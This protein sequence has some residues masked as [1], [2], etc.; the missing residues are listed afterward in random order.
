MHRHW[1]KRREKEWGT[2]GEWLK[3]SYLFHIHNSM[4]MTIRMID[5]TVCN[6]QSLYMRARWISQIYSWG[7]QIWDLG[8][9]YTFDIENTCEIFS[10][11]SREQRTVREVTNVLSA[12]PSRR[13]INR[14]RCILKF[15]VTCVIG[16]NGNECNTTFCS[17]QCSRTYLGWNNNVGSSVGV[18]EAA[19]GVDNSAM[20]IAVKYKMN[21]E[22]ITIIYIC[23][24]CEQTNNHR[25]QFRKIPY[26]LGQNGYYRA[27]WNVRIYSEII[28]S[29]FA[30]SKSLR[31]RAQ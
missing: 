7:W 6:S 25:W 14:D 21:P 26:V 16:D 3:F 30:N 31:S 22:G 8:T 12:I 18:C 2:H 15:R 20:V 17:L 27:H 23:I 1:Y 29:M 13:A 5:Q 19:N 24:D 4:S 11:M 9:W 28:D 10:G